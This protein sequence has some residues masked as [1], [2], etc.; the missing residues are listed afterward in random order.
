M[1]YS[2]RLYFKQVQNKAEAYDLAVKACETAYKCAEEFIL[3]TKKYTPFVELNTIEQKQNFINKI[4]TLRFTYW[5]DQKL[6]GLLRSL[7]ENTLPHDVTAMFDTY[8]DFQNSGD[9]DYEWEEWNDKI[10][11]FRFCKSIFQT[12]NTRLLACENNDTEEQMSKDIDYYRKVT[13][14]DKV[15]ETLNLSKWLYDEDET[16]LFTRF[17]LTPVTSLHRDIELRKILQ[18]AYM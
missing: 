1:S 15:F 10:N 8:V 13:M 5:D 3:K 16:E 11:L 18:T 14:Y 9:Q 2:F 17:A 7:D 4:F 6:L 12:A